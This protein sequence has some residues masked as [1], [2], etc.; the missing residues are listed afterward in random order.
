MTATESLFFGTINDFCNKICQQRTQVRHRDMSIYS[1]I[2]LALT[3]SSGSSPPLAI[4][5]HPV[6]RDAE[7]SELKRA[8][9]SSLSEL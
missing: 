6:G 8:F 3:L 2:S 1:I 4:V 9:C 7:R 5:L